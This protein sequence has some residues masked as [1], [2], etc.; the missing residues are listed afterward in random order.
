MTAPADEPLVFPLGHGMGPFH[1]HRDAPPSYWVIRLG[2]DSPLLHEQDAADVWTLAH[3][4]ADRVHSTPWT[5][6]VIR[7]VAR[8]S[9]IADSDSV[10]DGLLERGLAVELTPGSAAAVEFAGTHR[11]Q[12]LLLG[13]GALPDRP[14]VEGIGL[15]G[16]PALAQVGPRGYE[17]WQW[18]H[19]WPTLSDAAAG[20][21][22]LAAQDPGHTPDDVD[23]AA[24]LDRVFREL[25]TLLCGNAVYLDRSLAVADAERSAPPPR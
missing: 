16:M 4:T 9:G 25:H 20:L 3:G 14:E 13:L 18:A 17:F 23:P 1:Q 7:D 21:A 8:Q 12:S 2:W 22:E 10:L 5:R 11:V 24:V 19:L 6:S 15:L